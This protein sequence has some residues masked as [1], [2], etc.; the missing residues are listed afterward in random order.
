VCGIAGLVGRPGTGA[1]PLLLGR[2]GA[3]MVHR[4]PDQEGRWVGGDVGL[5]ARRLAIID[6]EGSDQPLH[7]EDGRVHLVLNGEIYNHRSL[8]RELDARGHRFRTRGDGE[9]IVHLYE[10]MGMSLVHRLRGMFAFALYD[11]AR[12]ALFLARDPFGIKPLMYAPTA[13][14]YAFGSD[15]RALRAVGAGGQVDPIALWHYLTYQYVPGEMS[16]TASVR[17]VPAGHI[18]RLAADEVRTEAYWQ[19]TL[20]PDETLE[21]A[22]AASA[23][24]ASLEASVRL[25]LDSDAPVGAFLSSGVDSSAIVAIAAALQPIDTFSVGFEGADP[26]RDE[27]GPARVVARHLGTRHHEV[28]IGARRYEDTWPAIVEAMGDPVADPSAAGLYFLSEAARAHVKVILSGEGADELFGGYPIYR[29]PAQLRPL[30]ALP[31]GLRGAALAATRLLP[32]G[33][34]GRAYALHAATPLERRYVGGAKILEDDVKREIAATD[35]LGDLPPPDPYDL[36]RPWYEA[37]SGLDDVGRMQLVDIHGWLVGD[38]LAKADRMTM[39]H[40]IEARV[41]YV[42]LDVFSIARRLPT[43]LKLGGGTTKRALR[44]AVRDLLPGGAADRPKLGFPVP[45]RQWMQGSLGQFARDVV[46]SDAWPEHLLRREA[47]RSLVDDHR[48]GR[49]DAA[50]VIYCLVT[51][52]LWHK[53]YASDACAVR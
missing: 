6:P 42:D 22:P 13:N 46:D 37:A 1:D 4:G 35:L 49:T 27:L 23:I 51:L 39:A 7:S 48:A 2:M 5:V 3:V 52:A 33:A 47:A 38:I 10:E 14:G 31:G 50:R 34:P 17:N 30:S 12:D 25:H 45:L 40:S 9:V 8:R 36:A 26:D 28:L 24:R 15:L 43:R 32:A 53:A 29:Q 21:A 18:V 16:L 19:P 11:E 41:P 20:V 44:A